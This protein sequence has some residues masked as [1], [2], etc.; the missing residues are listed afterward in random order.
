MRLLLTALLAFLASI[1]LGILLA[2][3][4]GRVVFM[5]GDWTAQTST[6]VFAVIIILTLACAWM[7]ARIIAGIFRMPRS[8][9]N[10]RL[11]RRLRHSETLLARGLYALVEGEWAAAERAFEKGAAHSRVPLI[12]YLYA[13]RAAQRQGAADRRDRYLELAGKPGAGSALAVGLTQAEMELGE[14]RVEQAGAILRDLETRQPGARQVKR[15]LLEASRRLRDW[16]RALELLGD[17]EAAKAL[18]AD[19]V[20]SVRLEAYA[21]LLRDAGRSVDRTRLDSVWNS[22]PRRMRRESGV[23][24]AYIGER[25][26]F[27]DTADCEELL[28]AYLNRARDSGLMRLYGMVEGAEQLKQLKNAEHWLHDQPRDPALLLTLG[29]LC[30]RSSLWGKARSYLDECI[31]LQPGP[32]AFQELA[33]LLEQQGDHAAAAACCQRGLALMTGGRAVALPKSAPRGVAEDRQRRRV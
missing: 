28:R 5:Y 30:R 1:A 32:E 23:I 31:S 22:T 27:P 4:T 24:E 13:A 33:A 18:P 12:H 17:L 7:L 9:K 20:R 10:W 11:G 25:L 14:G 21:G 2:K 15:L 26:R 16:G 6:S 19:Q 3:D 8:L 29:R